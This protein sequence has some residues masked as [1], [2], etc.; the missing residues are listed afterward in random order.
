MAAASLARRATMLDVVYEDYTAY[1][2]L[3]DDELL[4]MAIDRSLSEDQQGPSDYAQ[5]SFIPASEPPK[6]EDIPTEARQEHA[7]G[8]NAALQTQRAAAAGNPEV[9]PSR[10][11]HFD[12]EKEMLLEWRIRHGG[13]QEA[14]KIAVDIP[15]LSSAI[16]KNDV[17]RV[18]QILMTEPAETLNKPNAEGWIHLHEA[19]Y[20]NCVDCLKLLLRAFPHLVNKRDD[21]DQTPLIK[22]VGEKA[23]T[24]VNVLLC[25][26]G[27]PNIA[28]ELGETA[29]YKACEKGS[30]EILDALL[31]AGGNAARA[32]IN[33]VSPLHEAVKSNNLKMCKMLV[34]AGAEL[35][36][37][38]TYGLEPLFAAAQCG[39]MEGLKYFIK[40]GGNVNTQANDGA[41]ALYEASKNGHEECVKLLLSEKANA[42]QRSKS[43]LTP[44]HVASKNGHVNV[45]LQLIPQTSRT[46]IKLSSISPLHLAAE[47]NQDEVLEILI[48]EGF[49]VNQQLSPEHSKM[50]EDRRTTALY[51]AVRGGNVE[52]ASMLLEAGAD[53]NLD[54][55][56]PLLIAVRKGNVEMASL[57]IEHGGNVNASM[58]T[59]PTTFPAAMLFCIKH[60]RMSQTLLD[61]GLDADACFDCVYGNNTHPPVK[62]NRSSRDDPYLR[63]LAVPLGSTAQFCEVMADPV[64]L[65]WL[66]TIIDMLLDYT[67]HVKLCSRLS[68]LL[69]NIS[70]GQYIK[71]KANPPLA[72]LQ[73]CRLHVRKLVGQKRL[74]QMVSLPLPERLIRLLF[75]NNSEWE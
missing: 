74:R 34:K 9:N 27:D 67:G 49:D 52:A 24:S 1:G 47:C 3:T 30:E 20:N 59:Q 46:K 37:K 33:R 40:L 12:A 8:Q 68:N 66:G 36:I 21:L 17:E 48:R 26:G 14:E 31:K 53:P 35:G 6:E 25:A 4:Q 56:N 72:L 69:D 32:T 70:D 15:S 5:A 57:L 54:L 29:V 22:A 50:Y 63:G 71:D 42:N 11:P 28:N 75:Y 7:A 62:T 23:I 19:A 61:N 60:R 2:H 16:W 55:F 58:P 64:N 10:C 44:L 18:K 43:G 41:T 45:V 73:L 65:P 38:N 13:L 39:F 51:F